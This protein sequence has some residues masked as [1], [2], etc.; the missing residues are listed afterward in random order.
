[1]TSDHKDRVS[2]VGSYQLSEL[3]VIKIN[4][5]NRENRDNLGNHENLEY[6]KFKI[7]NSKLSREAV[8]IAVDGLFDAEVE[9]VANKGMSYTYFVE[10]W[11]HLME[12]FEIFEAEVMAGI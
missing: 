4:R 11:N 7:Q 2:I 5:E 10:P 1:M 8:K 6:S 3:S 9:G 12:I